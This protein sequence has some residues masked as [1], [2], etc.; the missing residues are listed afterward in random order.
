MS[1]DVMNTQGVNDGE[2]L[3]APKNMTPEQSS[4]ISTFSNQLCREM[5]LSTLAAHC[6]RELDH[7]RQGDPYMD[8]YGVELLRRA[9]VHDD[10]EARLWVQHCFGGLV[11]SWL[12]HHPEREVA[13]CLENE[14]TY[15]AQAFERF[16]YATIANQRL[17]FNQLIT[18]LHYLRASLHGAI[19]D[20]IRADALPREYLLQET[21]ETQVENITTS[22][23]A[24]EISQDDAH[25]ST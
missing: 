25:K 3:I 10:L 23:E 21:R 24:W 15:V 9:T 7:Y 4:T 19:I 8:T 5:K 16:W 17:E 20:K 12:H 6:L 18:A 22:S 2:P 13:C 14:E 1:S 11:R